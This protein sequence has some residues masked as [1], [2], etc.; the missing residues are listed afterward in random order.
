MPEKKQEQRNQRNES[1]VILSSPKYVQVTK[2]FNSQFGLRS[3]QYR[4]ERERLTG[5]DLNDPE[6]LFNQIDK[7]W[8]KNQT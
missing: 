3:I 7:L 6:I 8:Q 5:F 4:I 2:Y 1:Y